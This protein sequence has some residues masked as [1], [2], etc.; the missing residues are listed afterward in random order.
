ML[1]EVT[2]PLLSPVHVDNMSRTDP[3]DTICGE[4]TNPGYSTDT[5]AWKHYR[6]SYGK[7]LLQCSYFGL[8]ITLLGGVAIGLPAIALLYL[9]MN[10]AEFCE[11]KISVM[12]R[13]PKSTKIFV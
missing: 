5:L 2:I 8:A 11:W 4:Y 6:P 10:T 3:N 7:S 13:F 1:S 9:V 12:R